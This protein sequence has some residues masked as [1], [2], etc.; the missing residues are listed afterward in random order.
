MTEQLT[1]PAVKTPRPVVDPAEVEQ[2]EKVLRTAG[3]WMTAKEIVTACGIRESTSAERHVRAVASAA[4]PRV[5]SFPGSPGYRLWQFCTAE[6]LNHCIE[7]F[8][9]QGREMI[10]R[11]HLYRMAYHRRFR[12]DAPPVQPTF[13]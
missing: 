5:V 4:A 11:A 6:E 1:L 10:R 8:E 2:L 13:L 3:G 12:G 9:A 7:A